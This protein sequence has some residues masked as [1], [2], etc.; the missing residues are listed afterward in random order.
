[1]RPTRLWWAA[2]SS[3]HAMSGTLSLSPDIRR[4]RAADQTAGSSGRTS[5]QAFGLTL[6]VAYLAVHLLIGV[7]GLQSRSVA[8]LHAVVFAIV[9]I[10]HLIWSSRLDRIVALTV[11][12]ALCDG[13]WRMTKSGA[14]WEFP[15]YVLAAGALAVLLRFAR[16]WRGVG[17]PLVLL[18]CLLP[19]IVRVMMSMGLAP[20]REVISSTEMG[21]LSLGLAALAFRQ[22]VA[23]ESD[24]WNLLW[25][26][27]GPVVAALGV[28]TWSTLT[29]PDIKFTDESNFAVTGGFGPNQISSL[30]GLG[31][32][33]CGLLAFQRR[34]SI[35]LAVQA[36]LGLWLTW[37]VFLTFSRG[38]MYS[39]VVSGAAM[40]LVGIGTR[41]SRL[42]SIVVLVVGVIGLLVMFASANDFS[43]NWLESRY[44]D[45]TT[46]SST[47][48]RTN[49]AEMDLKVFG[50]HPLAGVGTGQSPKHHQGGNLTGAAAHTEYT[51]LVAEHGLP[52]LVVV[53]SLA[54]MTVAGFRANL[55]RW[56]RLL[57]AGAGVWALSTMLHASTRLAAVGLIFALTQLRVEPDSPDSHDAPGTAPMNASHPRNDSRRKS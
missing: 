46:S 43:G 33:L 20:S 17:A 21:L 4:R 16:P 12:G 50:D 35:Y 24:A 27:L 18:S 34:G 40:L 48:G 38:G 41:G 30:L 51:R 5:T 15:K 32:L 1:M 2:G 52:G 19:G 36:T 56:N 42:R 47:A 22:V 26:M 29:S 8:T 9:F 3:M 25:V 13:Y 23:S 45:G 44:N 11:Y 53:V 39:L 54:V 37:A 7:A 14:P 10:G 6:I 28:T 31:I 55:S 57:V 49:L